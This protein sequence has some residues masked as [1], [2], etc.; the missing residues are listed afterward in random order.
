MSGI[1]LFTIGTTAVTLADAF[2][3]VGA[4]TGAAGAL[5]TGQAQY[6]MSEYNAAVDANQA[7]A[8]QQAAEFE[9]T[10]HRAKLTRLLSSQKAAAGASGID[11]NTGSP[12]SVM[13]D[14]A[15][16]GELD[17]LAIRYGGQ[18]GAYRAN[19]QAELDKM[20]G[21]AAR[22]AGYYGAGA[23]LLTGASRLGRRVSLLDPLASP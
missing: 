2:T 19:S 8:S 22:T 6:D 18:V 4:V 1:E 7:I 5:S 23:S 9:E 20:Q 10:Q 11:P 12:L 17:A 14:T 3:V 15:E 13:A 16:Q 21:K